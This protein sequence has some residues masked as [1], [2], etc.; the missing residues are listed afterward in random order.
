MLNCFFEPLAQNEANF[1]YAHHHKQEKHIASW[2]GGAHERKG[3]ELW[4]CC[5]DKQI[6][7]LR[8]KNQVIH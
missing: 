2:T 7:P 4:I 8:L 3:S 6:L 1:G 5:S